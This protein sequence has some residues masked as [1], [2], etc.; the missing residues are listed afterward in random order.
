MTVLLLLALV[1]FG[2]AVFLLAAAFDLLPAGKTDVRARARLARVVEEI[3]E[4]VD[5]SNERD[6][7][8]QARKPW[9]NERQLLALERNLRLSGRSRDM[10][11]TLVKAKLI[12]PIFV[13]VVGLNYVL[14]GASLLKWGIYLGAIVVGYMGPDIFIRSRASEHQEELTRDLPDLLDQ[15]VIALDSGM[16]FESAFARIGTNHKGPIAPQISRTVQDMAVGVP[17][18]TAYTSL[19]E[20]NECEDLTRFVKSLIQ[21]EEFGVPLSN[22]VRLQAGEMREKRRQRASAAARTVPVKLLFPMLLCLFPILFLV[23]LTPAV[24]NFSQL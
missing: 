19:A 8:E 24:M 15:I 18:R 22:V 14:G 6:I 3:P 2:G 4:E 7:I 9:V 20:R 5:R 13:A 1:L 21:A 12:V 16:S 10:L 17:R 23:I 11:P